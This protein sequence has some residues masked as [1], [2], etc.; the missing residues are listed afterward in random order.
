MKPIRNISIACVVQA[1]FMFI[2]VTGRAESGSA[3]VE[4]RSYENVVAGIQQSY[5]EII[6]TF[7]PGATLM[8]LSLH[9]CIVSALRNN[10]DIEIERFATD[11]SDAGIQSEKGVFDP[12]LYFNTTYIE[13]KDPLPIRVSIATGGLSAVETEQWIIT[14]GLAGAIPTGLT[15]D[16][17]ASSEHTPFSTITDFFRA[18]GE[19]RFETSLTISQPVLKNFG[20]DINTTGIRVAIRN[21]EASGYQL[22]QKIMDTLFAVE[23]AYWELVFAYEN[24]R[25]RTKSL[26]LA[27]NLLEENRIRLDVGVIPPL[28]V[29]QSETGVAFREEEVIFALRE[30][31][32]RRDEL[33]QVANLF[34]GQ[35]I[36]DVEIVPTD[37]PSVSPAGEYK[38]REQI[39]AALKNR[40]ELIRLLKLQEAAEIGARFAKNQLLPTL[41]LNASV[42][43]IGLDDEFDSSFLPS[44]SLGLPVST[45]DKGIDPAI[46]DLFS[47]DNLQ[48][49]VG[50]TFEAPWG[51]NFEKGQYKAARLEA[52]QVDA[53]IRNLQLFIIQDVRNALRGIETDWNRVISTEK[54]RKYRVEN[55]KAERKKFDVGVS[56]AHDL[57]EFEEDLAEAEANEQRAIIDYTLSLTNL[58]RANGALLPARNV[59]LDISS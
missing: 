37:E 40:P 57:L 20:V 7:K 51:R 46:D 23:T 45:P 4:P 32:D 54:T 43:F 50:F 55:L 5:E 56:T 48:W 15:Y 22:A 28:A 29:L 27:Q 3:P 34:P 24:L 10:L 41:N 21:K 47:G 44:L 1:L 16:L 31:G 53:S 9:D 13:R 36:W 17:R 8:R 18:N 26:Q 6:E 33:I 11:I 52:S 25:V 19:Q 39:T 42:G 58:L 2:P 14:G 38:E 49:V 59:R 30:L 35:L 12:R